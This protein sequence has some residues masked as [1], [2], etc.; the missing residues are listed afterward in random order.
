M[1]DETKVI[2]T[3]ERPTY[4]RVALNTRLTHT[5]E[6]LLERLM[7]MRHDVLLKPSRKIR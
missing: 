1:N 4:R 7:I 6:V 2:Y 3:G 5:V